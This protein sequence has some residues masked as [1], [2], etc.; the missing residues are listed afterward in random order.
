MTHEPPAHQNMSHSKPLPVW[1]VVLLIAIMVGIGWWQR[2]ERPV[3]GQQTNT[4]SQNSQEGGSTNPSVRER[5]KSL[6]NDVDIDRP[7]VVDV[8]PEPI[9]AIDPEN[10]IK[11]A[12]NER[13]NPSSVEKS[14]P[15][16]SNSLNRGKPGP[17]S[18]RRAT[19]P[20]GSTPP[21]KESARS[22]D[23]TSPNAPSAS[24][25][26][27]PTIPSNDPRRPVSEKPKEDKADFVTAVK[28]DNQTIRN[29]GKVVF[30]GTVD[31]TPTLDRIARN[32]KNSHRNDGSTFGNRE[33]RLPKKPFGYY[34]EYVHPTKG[35][36]G[37]GPQRVVVGKDGDVWYTPNHY[38]S[39]KKVK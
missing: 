1:A 11:N 25:Q 26:K 27:S 12:T 38:E 39:F 35:I 24:S 28:V 6:T 34:T 22:T 33:G 30:K 10:R 13:S 16:V 18:G 17:L 19:G 20:S 2:S 15:K 36:D 23:R 3:S 37:P 21:M 29:Y 5:S 14:N 31:L 9:S 4:R 32:E 8:A 7:V